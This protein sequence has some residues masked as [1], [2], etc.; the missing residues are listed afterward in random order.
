MN[1]LKEELV[2]EQKMDEIT[3]LL[4][5]LILDAMIA[6]LQ[7]IG[8]RNHEFIEASIRSQTDQINF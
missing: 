5:E 4:E 6:A 1:L 2:Y 7:K 3:V 8:K